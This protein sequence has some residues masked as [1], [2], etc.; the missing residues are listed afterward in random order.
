[1]TLTYTDHD[2]H[3]HFKRIDV[4]FPN[5]IISKLIFTLKKGLGWV[6]KTEHGQ[7]MKWHLNSMGYGPVT[8][9]KYLE[10]STFKSVIFRLTGAL[11]RP[12]RMLF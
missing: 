1:L 4:N 10:L 11:F 9:N 6:F 2:T 5:G 7:M 3:S 12:I 8:P